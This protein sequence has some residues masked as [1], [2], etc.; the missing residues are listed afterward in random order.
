MRRLAANTVVT[1]L[2][3]HVVLPARGDER[4]IPVAFPELSVLQALA[5]RPTA[6]IDEFTA[7]LAADLGLDVDDVA[8]TI[9]VLDRIGLLAAGDPPPTGPEPVPVDRAQVPAPLA[10]DTQV[11]LN[12]PLSFRVTERGFEAIGHDG[13]LR[14]C[15]DAV[16]L[17][18]ITTLTTPSTPAEALE[19][20]GARAGHHALDHERFEALLAKLLAADVVHVFD[21]SRP[22]HTLG[23]DRAARIQRVSVGQQMRVRARHPPTPQGAQ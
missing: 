16:E 20:H 23:R 22:D 6:G 5:R 8:Q 14:A 9:R 4:P 18:A 2:T 19:D 10:A 15:L 3:R 7:N 13:E 17:D 1:A 12:T 21:E 11:V